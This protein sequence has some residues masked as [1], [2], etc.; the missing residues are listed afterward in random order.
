MRPISYVFLIYNY[1][2]MKIAINGSR[3]QSAH[4]PKLAELIRLLCRRADGGVVVKR[5]FC[6]Y[7]CDVLPGAFSDAA[8]AVEVVSADGVFTAD[9]AVSIGGD[10]TFL[11]TVQWVGDRHIPILGINTGHLGYL[12]DLTLDEALLPDTLDRLKVE[13]RSL[14]QVTSGALPSEFNPYALNEVAILK[15]D[16]SSMITVD[17][18]IDGA[19]LAAYLADGLIVATPTGS[20]GYS[21]SVGGPIVQPNAPV[22]VLAPVAPHSLTLRPL[23]VDAAST[24]EA[25]V[26]SRSE[27][28]LLSLDG[29][30]VVLP[31]DTTLLISRAP[32]T[33]AVLQRPT[34]HFASTLREKLL[35]GEN[36]SSR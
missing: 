7:L 16:T 29:R 35:W 17:T 10:G 27:S 5:K 3:R 25:T 15:Q 11:R 12:A 26:K 32:F 8:S 6:K 20:T 4:L 24:I 31:V 19:P 34:H 18:R 28:F 33:A 23:V 1:G 21:L 9:M 14:L 22:I 13:E 2:N 30:S 36:G